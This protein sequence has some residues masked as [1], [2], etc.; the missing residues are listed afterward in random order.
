MDKVNNT[1]KENEKILYVVNTIEKEFIKD[2]FYR[3]VYTTR[4]SFM[5]FSNKH[6]LKLVDDYVCK[7]LVITLQAYGEDINNILILESSN[8]YLYN[9]L[10]NYNILLLN[11]IKLLNELT[12]IDTIELTPKFK[13]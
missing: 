2:E 7:S 8:A 1:N 11:K 4:Y 3:S 12:E 10:I 9:Y 6:Y 5:I 13:L